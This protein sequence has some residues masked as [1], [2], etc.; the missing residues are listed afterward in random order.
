MHHR[1]P[2]RILC[3]GATPYAR[4]LRFSRN[5][6]P[7]PLPSLP[8]EKGSLPSC[9]SVDSTTMRPKVAG[10]L[11][12][13]P[14]P[15]DPDA[16]RVEGEGEVW[17]RNGRKKW[18]KLAAI[19]LPPCRGGGEG[20]V[21]TRRVVNRRSEVPLAWLLSTPLYPPPPFIPSWRQENCES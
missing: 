12:T 16:R 14:T 9:T 6:E 17:V 4:F 8:F 3:I 5:R 20:V 13:R 21:R 2:P 19:E 1:L 7:I 15:F 11:A 18:S 10:T